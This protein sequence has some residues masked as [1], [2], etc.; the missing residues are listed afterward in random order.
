M[1]CW[2]CGLLNQIVFVWEPKEASK[3]FPGYAIA[4]ICC[5]AVLPWSRQ[6]ASTLLLFEMRA[7]NIVIALLLH[8][9][10]RQFPALI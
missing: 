7:R 9:R 2:Q 10:E 5:L 3:G 1:L 4:L 8:V 6:P